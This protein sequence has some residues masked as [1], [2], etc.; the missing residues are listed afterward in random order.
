VEHTGVKIRRQTKVTKIEGKPG[1]LTV[2]TDKGDKIEADILLWAI[3]RQANTKNLGLENVGVK[4][5][6]KGDIVVDDYQNST[7]AGISSIG[8]VTG[9]WLLTPVAI[10]AGR[11]LANRLFGPPELKDDK[12]S[13]ENIATVV[14]S[15][16]PVGTVG[17]TEPEAR[18][19]YGDAVKVYKTS[20]KSLYFSMIE[21]HHKEPT[22]FKLVVQ[23]PE[24]RV[25]GIHIIGQGADEIIQGF[26]V[27]VK[28]GARKVD[29]DNTVAIHPTSGEELV[30]LR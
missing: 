2:Y 17:L 22:T 29:L 30:T 13:Y 21:D 26:A 19:K 1:N 5:T 11:R 23:G 4:T 8:D 18:K 10:A 7:V 16:P 3:G 12:L 14:F 24:E 15:H 28:M 25:V 9:K 20:F 27:A 6:P